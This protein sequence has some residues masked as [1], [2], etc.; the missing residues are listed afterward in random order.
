MKKEKLWHLLFLLGIFF[1]GL[2]GVLESVGGLSLLFLSHTSL[3]KYVNNVTFLFHE[4]LTE[5]PP[6]A[7]FHYLLNLAHVSENTQLFAGAYLVGHG[8]IK[9]AVVAG[10]YFK[11]LWVYPVA[12]V[13]L[14]LFILYQSYRFAHTHSILLLLLSIVDA[15]VIL[16]I[17]KERKRL[18]GLEPLPE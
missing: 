6:D 18:K 8:A 2:D 3:M 4:E 7:I 9:I 12:E 14:G 13:V 17:Y 5:K 16:L 10:L 15:A 1:K 11:K